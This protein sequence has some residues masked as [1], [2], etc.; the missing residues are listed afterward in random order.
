MISVTVVAKLASAL[1][2]HEAVKRR[3][4]LATTDF[5]LRW[6]WSSF[7]SEQSFTAADDVVSRSVNRRVNTRQY[8]FTL[9]EYQSKI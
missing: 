1:F 5:G 4:S 2:I 9:L 7:E 8:V 3:Y 6:T